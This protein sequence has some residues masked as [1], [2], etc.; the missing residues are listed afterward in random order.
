[1]PSADF[2][3]VVLGSGAAGL[4]AAL[5]AA[6]EGLRA[7]VIEKTPLIGGTTALSAGSVWVPNSHLAPG[8]DDSPAK[9]RRY[10][11]AIVGN[12]A[13][14]AL[15]TAFLAEAPNAIR[16]LDD[17][18]HVHLAPYPYHPD[19]YPDAPGAVL[20]GR[21]LLPLPFD[22]RTL[23]AD[24]ARLR[25]PLREF[26]VFGGMM[27]DRFDITQLLNARRS[28]K[29]F[30]HAFRLLARHARDRLSHPRGTRLVMGSALVGR[31]AFSLKERG[32]VILTEAKA[33]ELLTRDGAIAGVRVTCNG[34]TSTI[35]AKAVILAT[36]GFSHHP[37]LR[38][39]YLPSP[40]P[41]WSPVPSANSGDGLELA[42][43]LGA[44]IG[45]S[46]RTAAFWSPV[47]MRK[48]ADG[49]D[50]VFP[51]FVLDRGKPGLIA[52]DRS[53]RRFVNEAAPYHEFGLA[54]FEAD[55]RTP[56]IPCFFVCDQL[57][58][59]KYGLGMIRPGGWGTARAL[60]DGYLVRAASLA[61]L[62]EELGIDAAGLNETAARNNRFAAS[63]RD[64]DFAKGENAHNRNLGDPRHGP[65]PC[66]GPIEIPPFYA[67]RIYPGDFGAS[68]GLVTDAKARVLKESG[69]PIEGLYAC[70]NDMHSVMG[71][72]YPGPGITLGP[73]M[74]FAYI[75]ARDAKRLMQ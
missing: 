64:E 16:L 21:S 13:P 29:A 58:I 37:K 14:S 23:G 10:L 66:L 68:R 3:I 70:G 24:F 2:D 62:A 46:H 56:A 28:R 45:D 71:G 73:A 51:H 43:A 55:A 38:E 69:V 61:A 27:V 48:R 22:G 74:T 6:I 31:L 25:P 49:S 19:Y 63:G 39:A 42:R 75:A 30:G 5:V 36:G 54:M 60:R 1:M 4:T 17:A 12:Y 59:A 50:A 35:G 15:K 65:N 7:V 41:H 44:A 52:V 57:F 9:A 18:T 34:A 32:V 47:S 53:G 72:T 33:E 26:T 8:A 11:D 20:S 67:I 40:T